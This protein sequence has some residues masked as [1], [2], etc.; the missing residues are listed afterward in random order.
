MVTYLTLGDGDFTYSLDLA[1]YLSTKLIAS[2]CAPTHD[3]PQVDDESRFSLQDS[4]SSN[5]N[6]TH[7][8]N[9]IN[10]SS[11]TPIKLI[12]TGIDSAQV[13]AQKYKDSPCILHQ[14]YKQQERTSALSVIIRHG[15]NAIIQEDQSNLPMADDWL[16]S[17]ADHVMFHHPHLGTEDAKLHSR[18]LAHLFHSV[19][20]H[21]MKSEGGLF[22]LTLVQ[23]QFERWHCEAA[24]K[25]HGLV[26]L[27]KESFCPPP[28]DENKYHCRRHQSGR[29]FASRRPKNEST[30]FTFG[31]A[32]L[33]GDYRDTWLPWQTH[34]EIDW[35]QNNP[36]S[37]ETIVQYTIQCPFCAKVFR[38]RRSCTSHVRD[39]HP[40]I[41]NLCN[42]QRQNSKSGL[43]VSPLSLF[44]CI[45][46]KDEF[47]GIRTFQS[48]EAL[49][50]HML[51]K[52]SGRHTYIVPDWSVARNFE[53]TEKVVM[54][55][56][57]SRETITPMRSDKES[58][59]EICR[60]C[61]MDLNG[62]SLSDHLV[63]FTPST[64]CSSFQCCFCNKSFR[65]DRARLQHENFCSPKE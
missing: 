16:G 50:A 29:S 51:A 41:E 18:F 3:N 63:A 64:V 4:N 54:S 10:S 30:T 65:E 2:C 57:A 37:T 60:I 48:D 28:V 19:S 58:T 46:C 8:T 45:Y 34:Q 12:A 9:A 26:M 21:W 1:K 32:T 43:A 11:I 22:H 17:G 62:C 15:V 33:N 55:D 52:H 49:Q 39:K 13:L 23:G 5:S 61:G 7:D 27:H 36:P 6:N 14:I 25:R 56:Q 40:T 44:E 47:G 42:A 20:T 35:S 38:E 53:S 24:A 31:R 59:S